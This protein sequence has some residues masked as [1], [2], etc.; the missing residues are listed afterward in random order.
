MVNTFASWLRKQTT[1][2]FE[3]SDHISY[4]HASRLGLSPEQFHPSID[5]ILRARS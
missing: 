4:H 3:A 5:H 2:P 1:C